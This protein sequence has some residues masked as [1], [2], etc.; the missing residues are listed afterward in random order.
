MG[1]P[2]RYRGLSCRRAPSTDN[3]HMRAVP[4]ALLRELDES[5]GVRRGTSPRD[6]LTR[7][8]R[9][10]IGEDGEGCARFARPA[11]LGSRTLPCE[12]DMV[13]CRPAVSR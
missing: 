10:P 7:K 2:I 1:H 13:S 6:E 5:S 8:C 9:E 4:A 12:Y 11:G 3:A